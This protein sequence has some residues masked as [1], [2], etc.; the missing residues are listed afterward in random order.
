MPVRKV[1]QFSE[2]G[3]I[4]DLAHAIENG[5]NL[6]P[7]PFELRIKKICEFTELNKDKPLLD[8]MGFITGPHTFDKKSFPVAAYRLR[9][10]VADIK[11]KSPIDIDKLSL[12]FANSFTDE[13]TPEVLAYMKNRGRIKKKASRPSFWRSG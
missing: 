1:K 4:K 7:T 8:A 9:E 5:D 10:I 3:S 2:R 13:L 12:V 11:R 6:E